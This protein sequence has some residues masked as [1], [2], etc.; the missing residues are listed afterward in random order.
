MIKNNK[1][2]SIIKAWNTHTQSSNYWILAQSELARK[3]N[4][5]EN[6]IYKREGV[7]RTLDQCTNKELVKRVKEY[8]RLLRNDSTNIGQEW[9]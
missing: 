5:P 6:A 7:W 1:D 3:E 2:Y 8:A 9:Y 4:A